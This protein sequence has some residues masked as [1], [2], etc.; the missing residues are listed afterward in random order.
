[1]VRPCRL[2]LGRGTGLRS[3]L[4]TATLAIASSL[5]A[6]PDALAQADAG[7]AR[8]W[9]AGASLYQYILFEDSDFAIVMGTADRGK[10]HLEGRWNYEDLHAASAFAGWTFEFGDK[11]ACEV[12]PMLGVV[13]GSL[14]GVAP[15]LEL[16][17]SFGIVDFS[18]ESEYVVDLGDEDAS[19]FYAWSELGAHPCRPLHLGLTAQRLRVEAS[20]LE[21]DSGAFAKWTV[22]RLTA[23]GYLFNPW[24]DSKF[25]VVALEVA[26]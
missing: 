4:L 3:I 2:Y 17:A 18:V 5:A 14:W 10:L 19:F 20:A 1:M 12:T 8:P 23:A 13:G 7:G 21:V 16:Y 22:R 6:H 11:L 15:G 26:F 24:S 25:A 9:S